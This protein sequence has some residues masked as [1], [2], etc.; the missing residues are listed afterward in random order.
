MSTKL[1]NAQRNLV[2]KLLAEAKNCWSMIPTN[3]EKMKRAGELLLRAHRG[4]PKNKALI[5]FL[6][7]PGMKA[8]M[9]KTENFYMA[10]Q[11]K[12]MH[13]IDDE[14][15]FVIDEKNNTIEL[16]DKGID[17]LTE[18]YEDPT[19]L[20]PSRYGCRDCRNGKAD[21]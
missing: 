9:Q 21:T 5:K 16:T 20:Y 17:L 8:L 7:E 14:L 3:D 6:S 1:Y 10:E 2:T 11:S 19:F 12:N 13:I 15:F 4:L 18:S